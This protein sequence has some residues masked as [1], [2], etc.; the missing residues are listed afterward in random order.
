M[1]PSIITRVLRKTGDAENGVLLTEDQLA[2][3]AEG[4]DAHLET[5]DPE[6]AESSAAEEAK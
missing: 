3:L 6:P 2:R 4:T 1:E 5:T